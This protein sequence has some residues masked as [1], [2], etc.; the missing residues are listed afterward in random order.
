MGEF[1]KMTADQ[2]PVYLDIAARAYPGMKG[3]NT[4]ESAARFQAQLEEQI[5][6]YGYFQNE[7][8][9]GGMFMHD[10]TMN[11]HGTEVP[12]G[13]LG[14]VAVDLLHKKQGIAKQVVT[15]FLD[16]YKNQGAAIAMLY[17][18]RPDFYKKMG[19]GYGTRKSQYKF[20]PQSLPRGT[21]MTHVSYLTEGDKPLVLDCFDRLQK[22]R[23]GMARKQEFEKRGLFSQQVV[24]YKQDG[25]VQ[26]YLA[27][28]FTESGGNM[29]RNDIFIR[30]M[31][32]ETPAALSELLTFLHVQFDQIQYIILPTFE[33]EFL[34]VLADPRNGTHNLLFPSVYHESNVQGMGLMY[35]LIDTGRF[36]E[37]QAAHNF[38]GQT[39]TVAFDVKDSFYPANHGR[40]VVE[41]CEG[42]AHVQA[43]KAADAADVEVMIDVE[44][45]SSLV[46]GAVDFDSLYRLGLA[47]VSDE[48][49]VKTL[50]A[51]FYV[52]KKPVTLAAF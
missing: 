28:Q 35:R 46:M 52:R 32:W 30:E 5:S 27:F 37:Q 20:T 13:G 2:V 18:F 45:L 12:A 39:V 36:F 44:Y 22:A 8:L 16:H 50:D 3:L 42:H 31:F 11:V 10:I 17:P 51:L 21:S 47:R 49:Y 15:Y 25:V 41:F 1:R 26:G 34:H 43:T 38:G 24:V 33:E 14:F 9:V 29:L 19:F 23:H 7:Q 40:V 4:P 6:L 48:R